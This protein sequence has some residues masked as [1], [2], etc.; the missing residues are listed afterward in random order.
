M[1]PLRAIAD[2]N[3]DAKYDPYELR[4]L[5]DRAARRHLDQGTDLNEAVASVIKEAGARLNNHHIQRVVEYANHRAFR[6]L[7][8][9]NHGRPV[10]FPDGPASAALVIGKLRG[11]TKEATMIP[12]GPSEPDHGL[13]WRA[14]H[15][16]SE[17][18]E[19]AASKIEPSQREKVDAVDLYIKLGEAI[20][21][22]RMK[23][24]ALEE[25]CANALHEIT[26]QAG[27]VLRHGGSLGDVA[28]VLA[29]ACGDHHSL[30]KTAMDAVLARVCPSLGLIGSAAEASYEKVASGSPNPKHPLFLAAVEYVK[31]AEDLELRR[32]AANVLLN[33]R[34]RLAAVLR[35]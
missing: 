11:T 21:Q 12:T 10:E 33:S 29:A 35:Q 14:N 34:A 30:A 24:A 28:Q 25:K 8:Q 13:V 15:I 20:E 32:G 18:I 7:R 2:P 6:E 19:K 26:R 23:A 16:T 5:G 17:R 9:V 1:R 31:I 22:C 4:V 27:H 3:A